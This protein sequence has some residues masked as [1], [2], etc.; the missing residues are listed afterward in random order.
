MR[1][2]AQQKT[3]QQR[4]IMDA[5]DRAALPTQTHPASAYVSDWE[6][7]AKR[8]FWAGLEIG[9]S[10][11]AVSIAPRWDEYIAKRKGEIGR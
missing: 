2:P 6:I 11:G 5:F 3:E 4:K 7:E 8:A 10:M 9:A 1:N